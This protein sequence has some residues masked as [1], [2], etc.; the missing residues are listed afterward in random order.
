[1]MTMSPA[2]RSAVLFRALG[3]ET[4]LAI[5]Q[6]LAHG[7]HCVC[8]LQ[9]HLD[10]PQPLLSHHLKTLREAGL[11]SARREGRWNY[12]ALRPGVLDEL[13]DFFAGVADRRLECERVGTRLC[14]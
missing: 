6:L 7:E 11:I 14:C 2:G 4:R 5:V 3:D 8:E 13:L 10:V 12:Y 1:M 9:A